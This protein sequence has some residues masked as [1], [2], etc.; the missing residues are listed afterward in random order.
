MIELY[1]CTS[2]NAWKVAIIL[3]ELGVDYNVTL[4]DLYAGEHLT[5]EFHAINPNRKIPAIV[6]KAPVDGGLPITV[7]ESGAILTYLAEKYGKFLSTEIRS[8]TLTLQWMTWQV[9]GLG[10]MVGQAS[11]FVRFAPKDNPY[12]VSRYVNESLRL[13]HVLEGRL[14]EAEYLGG[15]YSIADM[16][17]WPWIGGF[18]PLLKMLDIDVSR[19]P[20]VQR[21]SAAVGGRKAVKAVFA[22][23]DTAI[24]PK[25]VRENMVL[26]EEEWSNL[27]G[28]KNL[29]AS[30]ISGSADVIGKKS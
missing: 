6:D 24:N 16:A 25:A 2:P 15:E 26:T 22:S 10:P 14:I 28:E 29:A 20:A 5:P 27:F 8:R 18:P 23:S 4:L 1:F 13:I 30:R 9:A 12:S 21:W 7:F 11:H 17:V 3:E 19:F